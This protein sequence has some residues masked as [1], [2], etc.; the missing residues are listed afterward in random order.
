LP[1]DEIPPA[2]ATETPPEPAEA[3]PAG[4][5]KVAVTTTMR[6]A[7]PVEVTPHEAEVLH[8]QGLLTH[9]WDE[10]KDLIAKARARFE[11]HAAVPLEAEGGP[12]L[13]PGIPDG[14]EATG[15]HE[16]P[17]TGEPMTGTEHPADGTLSPAVSNP[18]AARPAKG[19]PAKPQG[20]KS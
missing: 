1:A 19:R 18:P 13:L 17:G 10:L 2:P 8:H 12:G 7:E 14:A 4:P 6:P 5:L 15:E 3:A 16:H 11:G 9:T 20:D